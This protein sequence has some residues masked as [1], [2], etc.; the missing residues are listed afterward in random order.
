MSNHLPGEASPAAQPRPEGPAGESEVSLTDLAMTL[1]RRRLVV[2]LVAGGCVLLGAGAGLLK[3]RTYLISTAMEIGSYVSESRGRVPIESPQTVLAKI[4]EGIVPS[5]VRGHV[6]QDSGNGLVPKIGVRIP[7]NSTLVVLESRIGEDHASTLIA[8]QQAVVDSVEADHDVLMQAERG[9]L[10]KRLEEERI[11]LS[12]LEDPTTLAVRKRDVESRLE[13]AE[14][15]LEK[16]KLDLQ[17][18]EDPSTLNAERRDLEAR[19]KAIEL[20]LEARRDP[21]L[22]AVPTK[23]LETKL[24]EA[25]LRLQALDEEA[26]LLEQRG[27][28]MDRVE[29]LLTRQVAE[30]RG[31]LA[32]TLERRA[33]AA[34]EPPEEGRAL[35]LLVLDNAVQETRQRLAAL[36]ERLL[37]VSLPENRDE[38]AKRVADNRRAQK[39]QS[40]EIESLALRLDKIAIDN[41][42]EEQRLQAELEALQ[43]RLAK[44]VADHGRKI[45]AQ[46]RVVGDAQAMRDEQRLRLDKLVHDHQR[47]IALEKQAVA[48]VQAQIEYLRPT[49]P[50]TPPSRSL[51]P[52]DLGPA[53]L[54][55]L[56]AVLG[57]VLGVLAALVVDFGAGLGRAEG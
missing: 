4:R 48:E 28:S 52:V 17:A 5:V 34:S 49:R 14:T 39:V 16:A 22:L 1:W 31:E 25:R 32:D 33:Q 42:L 55:A 8:L 36:E 45:A 3:S 27:V 46:R 40:G 2:L 12:E 57:L 20:A 47:A 38:L 15:A 9:R 53:V 41:A 21:R 13:A 18:L 29:E 51:R 10:D 30:L 6:E 54:L 24:Q 7:D 35:T 11:A 43:A 23:Q 37:F 50:I 56:S 19:S 44:L 26:K